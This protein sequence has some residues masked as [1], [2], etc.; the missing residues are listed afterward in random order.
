MPYNYSRAK[1]YFTY[2]FEYI[3][4]GL[5]YILGYFRKGHLLARHNNENNILL[6]EPFQMGD[7]ISL[8]VLFDPILEKF[9]NANIYLLLK[10]AN[11]AVYELDKRIKKVFL[12][13]FPWSDYDKKFSIKK[14]SKLFLELHRIRS[15]YFFEI[16]IDS[17][18]DLRSQI[19]LVFLKC[20]KRLGYLTYL[21]SNI[22]VKGLLLTHKLVTSKLKHRFDSNY[23]LLSLLG[24]NRQLPISF[25]TLQYPYEDFIDSN[26]NNKSG[27]WSIVIH[28]GGG[29]KYKKWPEQNWEELIRFLIGENRSNITL[30][31]SDENGDLITRLQVIFYES[32]NFTIK[33][34]SYLEMVKIIGNSNL[35]ICLDSGPMNIAGCLKKDV[36]AL[37]GPGDSMNWYPYGNRSFYIHHLNQYKCSPCFQTKCVCPESNCM[38]SIK[39]NDVLKVYRDW[40]LV[41]STNKR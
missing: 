4:F 11:K 23:E 31:Y 6:I 1:K 30:I 12:V 19:I 29:S 28:T 7:V 17:R 26:F 5:F 33:K 36:I 22:K 16:G 35:F 32:A 9:P 20:R 37:F 27:K 41:I 40:Q 21:N 14:I 8:S 38:M 39:V 15:S 13:D 18:G 3:F 25:P 34:T 2:I 24:I 10:P